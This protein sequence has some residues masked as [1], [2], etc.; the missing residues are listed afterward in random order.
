MAKGQVQ[1]R[2]W[3]HTGRVADGWMPKRPVPRSDVWVGVSD[4][5]C[6]ETALPNWL[7]VRCVVPAKLT[8]EAV[9]VG[10]RL[11]SR[12]SM[13]EGGSKNSNIGIL[14]AWPG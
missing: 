2:R 10:W 9:Q 5:L 12:I 8:F 11:A 1:S 3:T 7:S 14:L 13:V 4:R 6:R